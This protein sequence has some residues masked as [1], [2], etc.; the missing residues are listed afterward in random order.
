[1]EALAQLASGKILQVAMFVL[2]VLLDAQPASPVP[3]IVP[4]AILD[5]ITTLTQQRVYVLATLTARYSI[6]HQ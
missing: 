1:V 6:T 5:T 4:A 2:P 3:Q